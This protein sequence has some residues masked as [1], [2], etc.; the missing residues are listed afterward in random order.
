MVFY[1]LVPVFSQFHIF[2]NFL[3]NYTIILIYKQ[4]KLYSYSF[5]VLEC[6]LSSYS[7]GMKAH[8]FFKFGFKFHNLHKAFI[9]PSVEYI[10]LL[11]TPL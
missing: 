10:P 3:N 9:N 7:F 11:E 5:R 6:I 4:F 1:K 2:P 8:S